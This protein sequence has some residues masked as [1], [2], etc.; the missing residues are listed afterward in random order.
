M[1]IFLLALCTLF[2][3]VSTSVGATGLRYATGFTVEK[4]DGVTLIRV[5]RPW[6][7]AAA[8]FFYL[9]K[10]PGQKTPPGYEQY[11]VVEVPVRRV[12]ALST[13]VIGFLDRLD[14]ADSLIGFSDPRRICTPAVARRA[15]EG[16]MATVG[17]GSNLQV[18]KL[19]ALSPDLIFTFATG[20][21]R[22]THPKLIEAG[23][24][25]A[26]VGEYMEEHPLGRAEWIKYIG[27]FFDREAEAE[28]VFSAVEARYNALVRTVAESGDDSRPTTFTGTPFHGQW[29]VAGGRSY[30][31]RLLADAGAGYLWKTSDWRGAKP[32]DVEV[33]FARA[34]NADKWLN[35]GVWKSLRQGRAADP[36]FA[37]FS[38]L[39]HGEL[40]NNNRRVNAFGSND[41]WESGVVAPDLVLADLVRIFHPQLLPDHKLYYYMRLPE[42]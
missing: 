26:L 23:L 16:T 6:L 7:G 29:H 27:L 14:V 40:Y 28:K 35:P 24:P 33:V 9:L 4:R 15:E 13:T 10:K 32:V 11:Q 5:K 37:R 42:K 20:S 38:S 30:V 39:Q 21:F 34:L 41:Y 12:V 8:E 1:R 22:D 36:R 2:L 3:C 17:D 31:A 19:L 25:V 18:E